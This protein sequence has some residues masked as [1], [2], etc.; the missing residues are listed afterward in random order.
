MHPALQAVV[1]WVTICVVL[2]M[3][4]GL[5]LRRWDAAVA[6]HADLLLA[7]RHAALVQTLLWYADDTHWRRTHT[8]GRHWQRS[9]TAVDRGARARRALDACDAGA[10]E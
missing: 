8:L 6:N 1:W 9:A 2:S 3:V 7:Q 10:R 5:V 4:M